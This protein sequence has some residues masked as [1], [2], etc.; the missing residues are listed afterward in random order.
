MADA[1]MSGFTVRS[2]DRRG[3]RARWR[4]FAAAVAGPLALALVSCRP[5]LV[6]RLT[7]KVLLDG[8]LQRRVEV[9]G[10][11]PDGKVPAKP[12]WMEEEAHLQLADRKAWGRVDESPGYLSAEGF[13][14]TGEQ[15]PGT[16]AHRTDAGNFA[17]RVKVA[18]TGENLIVL[19]RWV[20]KESWSDPYGSTEAGSA[21]DRLIDLGCQ[22]LHEEIPRELGRDVDPVWAE[23]LLRGEG[24]ALILE[25][26]SVKARAPGPARLGERNKIW[27]AILKRHGVSVAEYPEEHFWE[28]QTDPILEWSKQRIAAALSTPE[29][30]IDPSDMPFWPTAS[31]ADQDVNR[32]AEHVWGSA[33]K[34]ETLVMPLIEALQGY[35]GAGGGPRFRFEVRVSLPGRMLRTNGTPDGEGAL[36]FFRDEDLTSEE[37]NLEAESIVLDDEKLRALGARR[38]F[39]PVRLLQLTDI[40]TERDPKGVVKQLLLQAI[41]R[42]KLSVLR[43]DKGIPEAVQPLAR[44]L[45]NLLDPAVAMP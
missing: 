1:G 43:D 14:M 20:F 4:P 23:A 12:G 6:V 34:L 25:A 3:L 2:G 11:E 37:K 13:F 24:R 17:D 33:D 28:L 29:R 7:T 10:R 41:E 22:V 30:R 21:L 38:D 15:V 31:G 9:I 44:E 19:K 45:A 36:W 8:G 27:E 39:E 35:Y 5:E 40:L 42:G 18:V 26:L 16:L 32:I